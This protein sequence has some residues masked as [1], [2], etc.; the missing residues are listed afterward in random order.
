MDSFWNAFWLFLGVVAGALIQFILNWVST[1]LQ[2]K[3]AKRVFRVETSINRTALEVLETSL[4][5][6]KERFVAG[7]VGDSDYFIDMSAFNYRIV[8]PLINA[9]YF[10]DFLGAEGVQRYMRYAGELNVNNAQNLSGI[11]RQETEAGRSLGFLDWLIDTKLPEWDGH[12]SF[13]ENRLGGKVE[14]D[15]IVY[16]V[17]K[18][19]KKGVK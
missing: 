10:H 18:A 13:V 14:V 17:P 12:L 3:S 19:I 1:R 11:L 8:D 9:G 2:R 4:N 16:T 7:Q 15:K 6:K 5:R